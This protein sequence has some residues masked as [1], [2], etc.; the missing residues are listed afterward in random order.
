MEDSDF[1]LLSDDEMDKLL[2]LSDEKEEEEG[3]KENDLFSEASL[4]DII[5][6]E[7]EKEE[8]KNI[9]NKTLNRK[10][11]KIETKRTIQDYIKN[12]I[13]TTETEFANRQN[14]TTYQSPPPIRAP[15]TPPSVLTPTTTTPPPT[16]PL[17]RNT[18]PTRIRKLEPSK[19][20]PS[21]F[22]LAAHPHLDLVVKQLEK[23][24]TLFRQQASYNDLLV[25]LPK[26]RA[27][28]KNGHHED[29]V[30]VEDNEE[31]EEDTQLCKRVRFSA[32]VAYYTEVETTLFRK[33]NNPV[34]SLKIYTPHDL[35]S[36]M[37][38]T[39]RSQGIPDPSTFS[40]EKKHTS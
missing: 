3:K 4:K 14:N 21:L 38:H 31:D 15:Y 6:D 25:H 19:S 13:S 1:D 24:K 22:Q 39:N 27:D 8:K 32:R 17:L 11:K 16:T 29:I 7:E 30:V 28:F 18:T 33:L 40:L 37:K 26:D 23:N 2:N 12:H 9:E 5:E 36:I 34:A 10:L 20:A 35:T